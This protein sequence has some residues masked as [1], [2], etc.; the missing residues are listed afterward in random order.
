M[1]TFWSSFGITLAISILTYGHTACVLQRP[2]LHCCLEVGLE[3]RATQ[4]GI[5]ISRISP[6][7]GLKSI[8]CRKSKPEAA[9]IYQN[10]Q[11]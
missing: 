9:D 10:G 8:V 3:L 2:T 7:I 11:Q 6:K 5:R 1:A 4:S